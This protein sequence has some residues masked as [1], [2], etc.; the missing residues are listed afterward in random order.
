MFCAP[1]ATQLADLVLGTAAD[2]AAVELTAAELRGNVAIL[3]SVNGRQWEDCLLSQQIR[4][5]GGALVIDY[6]PTSH[7]RDLLAGLL[8]EQGRGDDLYVLDATKPNDGDSW[9]PTVSGTVAE[10]VAK[11]LA[12][13]PPTMGNAD[14]DL[15]KSAL[16][17]VVG[18][19]LTA[20]FRFT[21]G[22]IAVLL[23]F[24][25]ALRELLAAQPS[26]LDA[27]RLRNWLRLLGDNERTTK[28]TLQRLAGHYVAHLNTL[29]QDER[30]TAFNTCLPT[31]DFDHI[32]GEGKVLYV[33]IERHNEPSRALARALCREFAQVLP[34]LQARG[35]TTSFLAF[36]GDARV[37]PMPVKVLDNADR[38]GI[39]LVLTATSEVS[40]EGPGFTATLLRS[41]TTKIICASS[42]G[43][44][45]AVT[46]F[47]GCNNNT[48]LLL[49]RDQSGQLVTQPTLPMAKHGEPMARHYPQP[50]VEGSRILAFENRFE[51]EVVEVERGADV[52]RVIEFRALH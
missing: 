10:I 32:I 40:R 36:I 44:L 43:A 30:S 17:P 47:L 8:V 12:L 42:D 37:S 51:E 38:V 23:C 3:G 26:A 21:V 25:K 22:D 16:E 4:A 27:Q 5:G 1:K 15:T 49:R 35:A 11:L 6:W 41:V 33:M 20:K 46:G 45:D 28:S 7:R 52:R 34:R 24:P 2:G 18:A 14:R 48:S 19:L 39:G 29:L 13:C 50:L 31:I 9:S